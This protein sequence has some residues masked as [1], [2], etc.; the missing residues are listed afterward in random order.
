MTASTRFLGFAILAWAGV[1]AA[2]LGL[3]P[4]GGAMASALPATPVPP[5]AATEFAP[6]D[7]LAPPLPERRTAAPDDEAA[8]Y[9]DDEPYF[10]PRPQRRR[11]R[12]YAAAYYPEPAYYQLRVPR[13]SRAQVRYVDEGL[14]P[15]PRR[16][17]YAGEPRAPEAPPFEMASA[18]MPPSHSSAPA[19]DPLA[20]PLTRQSRRLELS[21]W[22]LMRGK[23]GDLL[24]PNSLAASGATLGGSQAGARLTYWA[25]PHLGA[26]LRMSSPIGGARGGEAALGVR[27]RP[28]LSIPFAVTAERRQRF[29]RAGGR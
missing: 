21:S 19:A 20:P 5:V 9:A 17:P 14:M 13:Q 6:L 2:S 8:A 27:Y 29:G 12:Q 16:L 25:T 18:A 23:P 28:W 26:S 3:V 24:G 10:T 7:P 1:R 22:A 4:N 15:E 11:Y